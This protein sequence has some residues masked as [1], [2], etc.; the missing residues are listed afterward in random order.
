MHLDLLLIK[1]S[2]ALLDLKELLNI[3]LKLIDSATL[4]K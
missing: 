2:N 3:S 1:E 4:R